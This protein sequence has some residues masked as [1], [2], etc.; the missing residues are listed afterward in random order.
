[1]LDRALAIF[2][3]NKDTVPLDRATI[4]S[5]QAALHARL[6]ELREAER[7]LADALSILGREPHVDSIVL[8]TVLTNYAQILR[9]T[10]HRREARSVEARASLLRRDHAPDAVVD[11]TDLLPKQKPGRN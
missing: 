2:A 7:E 11:V 1:V 6:G 5:V 8:A 3:H 4:L 9:K 10:H